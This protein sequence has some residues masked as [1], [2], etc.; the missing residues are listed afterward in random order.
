MPN[1]NLSPQKMFQ[2]WAQEQQPECRFTGTTAEEFRAW[3]AATLPRV[4]ATLGAFPE[5]VPLNPELVA[6]WEHDGLRKQRWLIDVG[7]HISA[8]FQINIPL[9]LA[10]NERRPALLC[11]H[12]HGNFGK[13]SVMGNDSSPERRAEISQLNYNYGHQM[14]QAGFVTFAIDWIGMG[15]RND[16]AKPHYHNS[17]TGSSWCDLYYIAATMLGTTS[18]AIN[19]AHGMAATDFACTFPCIDPDRLGVMGLSGGGTMTTWSTIC[20]PRFKASEIICYSDLWQS[21]IYGYTQICGMQVAPGL[22]KLVELPDLQGLIAPRPLLIGIA[23]QDECFLLDTA[24]ECYHRLEAIYAA[25]GAT[26]HLHFDLFP[27]G[28]AWGGN[29]SVEFFSKYIGKR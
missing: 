15:E 8:A 23:V 22:Y 13:D 19:V 2:H 21:I 20:D 5:R 7:R 10:P 3:H 4:L 24:M 26:K 16:A 29:K 18:L 17:P 12:G 11:W 6:E 9:D 28:H 14:A 1:R 27:G 25:G